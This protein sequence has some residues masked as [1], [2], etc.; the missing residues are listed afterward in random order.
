MKLISLFFFWILI[1][2]VVGCASDAECQNGKCVGYFHPACVCNPGWTTRYYDHSTSCQ[3]SECH[4]VW[5]YDVVCDRVAGKSSYGSVIQLE[6]IF[7]YYNQ[8]T[9]PNGCNSL[10]DCK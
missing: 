6:S 10:D 7:I 8:V 4:L 2:T 9:Y 3:G 5:G 1:G